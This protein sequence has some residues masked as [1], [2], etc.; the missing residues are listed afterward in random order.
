MKRTRIFHR[1]LR[2]RN[3]GGS[4]PL[5]IDAHGEVLERKS[6]KPPLED[7]AEKLLRQ[8]NFSARTAPPPATRSG[9]VYKDLKKEALLAAAE[10]EEAVERAIAAEKAAE[11]AEARLANRQSHA[12]RV[13]EEQAA[14]QRA[15]RQ[16]A[17][18][19]AKTEA[20]REAE[21]AAESARFKQVVKQPPNYHIG[22][23]IP[24][25]AVP[26]SNLSRIG[27]DRSSFVA[28]VHFKSGGVYRYAYVH[29][30]FEKLILA[31][32]RDASIVFGSIKAKCPGRRLTDDEIAACSEYVSASIPAPPGMPETPALD[33]ADV[34]GA[35]IERIDGKDDVIGDDGLI[36]G[37]PFEPV[38]PAAP[39]PHLPTLTPSNDDIDPGDLVEVEVEGLLSKLHH[40]R[41]KSVASEVSEDWGSSV[42]DARDTI[43]KCTDVAR[44]LV[45]LKAHHEQ[46]HGS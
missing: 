37:T 41:L 43:R 25:R 8:K 13:A 11:A 42:A 18:L 24:T 12:Q 10:A 22:H 44:V 36:Q 7:L 23:P 16:R 39:R 2:A 4:T 20:E 30:R 38:D 28:E 29:P 15:A 6:R 17:L 3:L 1:T 40:T 35:K 34:V 33:V 21:R 31:G 26:S 27:Y 32:G 14:E 45:L 5:Y 9:G 46:Q 19:E